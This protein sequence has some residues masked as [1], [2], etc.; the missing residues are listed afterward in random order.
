MKCFLST[1]PTGIVS[2]TRLS[3]ERSKKWELAKS[4]FELSRDGTDTL[5]HF[6]PK[7]HTLR[8]I[9]AGIPGHLPLTC[10]ESDDSKLPYHCFA[11][12]EHPEYGYCF[13]PDCHDRYF[14]DALVDDG[15]EVQ[16]SLR[17]CSDIHLDRI[18]HIRDMELEKESGSKFRQPP[19]IEALFTPERQA[20]L[21]ALRD[22]PQVWGVNLT[23]HSAPEDI[24]ADWPSE[25]PSP[26]VR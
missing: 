1:P 13:D 5:T 17:K 20:R 23:R 4:M 21:E 6:N 14:R 25:L 24:K 15:V 22:I 19:E 8:A 9:S 16:I 7:I 10:R 12:E 3:G 11:P 26:A 18:R 2:I